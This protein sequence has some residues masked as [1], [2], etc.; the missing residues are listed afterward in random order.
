MAV[1]GPPPVA[2][3]DLLGEYP[4]LPGAEDLVA[5][6]SLA[7]G[8]LVRSPALARVRSLGLARARAGADDPTS[9]PAAE[10]LALATPTERF[11][12][13]LYARLLLSALPV[14][15]PRRRWA[16]AEA[17][18]AS[19]RIER[20]DPSVAAR[21][22]GGLGVPMRL[23]GD[24]RLSLDVADYVRLATPIREEGFRLAAQ[25]VDRGRVLVARARAARLIEEA[26]R[27]EL[28]GPRPVD[29]ALAAEILAQAPDLVEAAVRSVPAPAVIAAGS[30]ARPEWFPPCI[31]R[32]RRT[33]ES[34]ENLSHA[35][36]FAL[37]AF[38]HRAGVPPER[39][40]DAY[41]GAPDF[42]E[43]ITR[44]QVDHIVRRDGGRGYE[45]PE[46]ATI[47]SH[48]LCAREGDPTAP[49]PA[50]RAR[51]PRCFDPAL[52]HPLQYYRWR[53]G[54]IRGDGGAGVTA[55]GEGG[56]DDARPPGPGRRPSTAPR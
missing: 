3:A 15:A 53:G 6:L 45:P 20:T 24:G 5:G 37:A 13:F 51:D 19:A 44:Y 1:R 41:R 4:F 55:A 54:T 10:E 12:S 8:D 18:A 47:R 56:P 16:V 26:V 42:D 14:P 28:A 35:G 30:P 27:R 43:G 40:V 34:G 11:L 25:T 52:R 32:M 36:R 9:V 29:P 46:C 48:G 21:I 33:L 7:V 50:D 38:L 39:I 49:D 23:E 22:A 31:Q 17:K 2:D